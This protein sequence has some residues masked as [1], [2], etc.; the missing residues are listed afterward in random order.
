MDGLQATATIEDYLG[1]GLPEFFHDL[2]EH[3]QG[4]SGE[5]VWKSRDG[6]LQFACTSTRSGKYQLAVFLD[7]ARSMSKPWTVKATIE[8][9]AGKLDQIAASSQAFFAF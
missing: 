4:W 9:E 1:G 5:K 3:W 2:A 6:V 7:P 8:L